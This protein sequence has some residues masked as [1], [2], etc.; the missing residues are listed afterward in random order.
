MITVTSE[1]HEPVVNDEFTGAIPLNCGETLSGDMQYALGEE[2]FEDLPY[3]TLWYKVTG[4]DEF[5]L[6]SAAFRSFSIYAQMAFFTLENGQL[7]N[8]PS[9]YGYPVFLQKDQLYYIA[10]QNTS[11]YFARFYPLD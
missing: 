11:A 2:A 3:P 4:T 9:E 8:Y 1:V 6:V 7:N 10:V 5:Y